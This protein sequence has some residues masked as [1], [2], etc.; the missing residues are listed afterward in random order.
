M[1]AKPEEM[2]MSCKSK[3]SPVSAHTESSRSPVYTGSKTDCTKKVFYHN[4]V[5]SP[6]N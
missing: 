3:G 6:A 5:V 4:L 1:A 2:V